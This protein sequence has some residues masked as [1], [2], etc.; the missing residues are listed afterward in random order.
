MLMTAD[1]L[2]PSDVAALV[3]LVVLNGARAR[4]LLGACA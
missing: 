4:H 1:A 3:K 2:N